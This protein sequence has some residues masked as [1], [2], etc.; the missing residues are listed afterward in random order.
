M[1]RDLDATL[2]EYTNRL[3]DRAL[4][5]DLLS[6]RPGSRTCASA[7]SPIPYSMRVAVAQHRQ[8]DVGD[9]RA[10]GRPVHL[11]GVPRRARR[12]NPPP[13][14]R[15]RGVRT[16]TRRCLCFAER[17]CPPLME[18]RLGRAPLR[19]RRHRRTHSRP[20]SRLVDRPT[21]HREPAGTPDYWYPAPPGL[22]AI[23][24]RPELRAPDARVEGG[25]ILTLRRRGLSAFDPGASSTSPGIGLR[26]SGR[27]RV[28][29]Q[30]IR[31]GSSMPRGGSSC[32]VWS[33]RTPTCSRWP[34]AAWATAWGWRRGCG[35][36]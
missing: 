18:G 7:G 33:T 23:S 31:D 14:R 15:A 22:E 17:G 1:V 5:G 12:G 32:R 26:R 16:T 8:H 11:Q 27:W 29:P 4:A 24:A 35:P 10:G 9:R 36:T 34:R 30:G 6:G 3:R 20:P 19:L 2:E 13:D 25:T 21:G 28:A